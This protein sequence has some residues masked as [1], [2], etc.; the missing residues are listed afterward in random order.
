MKDPLGAYA[1]ML[2]GN[3][4]ERTSHPV[5]TNDA[6]KEIAEEAAKTLEDPAVY[7]RLTFC[8]QDPK[9]SKC[10]FTAPLTCPRSAD[11]M[12]LKLAYD[13]FRAQA[14]AYI[15]LNAIA[16][17]IVQTTGESLVYISDICGRKAAIKVLRETAQQLT[18]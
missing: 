18:H 5:V 10:V 13:R 2:I 6:L 15:A 7:T 4:L 17:K 8:G 16:R 12:V 9:H 1:M 14:P 3:D 11:A